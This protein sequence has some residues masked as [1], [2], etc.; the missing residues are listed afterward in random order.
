METKTN[1]Y[2]IEQT[3]RPDYYGTTKFRW[4]SKYNGARGPWVYSKKQAV[5]DGE[6]H[7]KIIRE[8]FNK[9]TTKEVKTNG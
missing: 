5:E 9:E 8:L 1:L 7:E 4:Y 6:E 3:D 2:G